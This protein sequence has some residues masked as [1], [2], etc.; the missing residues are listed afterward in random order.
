[1]NTS[2][3]WM[4]EHIY[5]LHS[6]KRDGSTFNI[7]LV[8]CKCFCFINIYF[9][10]SKLCKFVVNASSSEGLKEKNDFKYL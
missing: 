9:L 6:S 10:V 7:T 5:Y 3:Y 1:M 4:L 8:V 2:G